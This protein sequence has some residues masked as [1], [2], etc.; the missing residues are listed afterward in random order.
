M[1]GLIADVEALN[2]AGRFGYG[3]DGLS[4]GVGL[5][6]DRH[7]TQKWQCGLKTAN[8]SRTATSLMDGAS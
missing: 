8:V 2:D 3:F 1:E 4:I 7:N 6:A 5:R